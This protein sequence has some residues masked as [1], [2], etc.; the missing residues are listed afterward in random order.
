MRVPQTQNIKT[1]TTKTELEIHKEETKAPSVS[2]SVCWVR[3]EDTAFVA[4]AL[5]VMVGFPKLVEVVGG[6]HA[7]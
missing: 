6:A 3:K 4:R 7:L 2:A 1:P 5:S